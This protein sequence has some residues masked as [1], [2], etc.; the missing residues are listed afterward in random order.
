MADKK[1]YNSDIST[2]DSKNLKFTPY[3]WL[4]GV[5][6][7]LAAFASGFNSAAPN[8]PES[9]IRN[10]DLNAHSSGGLPACLPM[11]SGTW[12]LA[13]GILAIGGLVGGL[14]AGPAANRFGRKWTLICNN[15]FFIVGAILVATATTVAQFVAGRVIIGIACGAASV[16]APMYVAEISTN[17]ARGI[18][19]TMYQLF[20]VIGI[21]VANCAGIGLTS[22]PGWRY[23]FGIAIF[24]PILQVI[25]LLFCTESPGYLLSKNKVDE[26]RVAL[27]KLRSGC[28]IDNEFNEMIS[29]AHSEEGKEEALNIV[30]VLKN[31]RLCK[32]FIVAMIMHAY[33]QL[34][35]INSVIFYSTNIFNDIF[36]V[37]NSQYVTV[38]VG[39]LNLV[40]TLVSVALIDRVGRKPLLYT[41]GIGMCVCSVLIVIASIYGVNTLMVVAVMLFVATFA[42][43]LGPIPWMLMPELIPTYAIGAASSTATAVNWLFNFVIG[44]TFPPMKDALGNYSFLP[45][46]VICALGIVYTFFLVPETKGRN[47]NEI[48]KQ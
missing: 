23:L 41:S 10:C 37:D 47:P 2:C 18:L 26:A 22:V 7:A 48:S 28:V 8:T 25:L 43:G 44:Q 46:A 19:G 14:S 31:S 11:S 35:G 13:V 39:C 29:A 9:V 4:C 33:Q 32:L 1:N 34:S 12:G 20:T 17:G 40:M 42:V 27:Q 45:Y 3:I 6:A 24:P 21:L 36:G 16:V 15:A 38:G 30:Q 5:T